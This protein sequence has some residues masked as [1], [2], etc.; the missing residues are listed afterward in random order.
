MTKTF[1]YLIDKLRPIKHI[2]QHFP[3]F[4]SFTLLRDCRR[5]KPL[6]SSSLMSIPFTLSI[7]RVLVLKFLVC[8]LAS[9]YVTISVDHKRYQQHKIKVLTFCQGFEDLLDIVASPC[10]GAEVL[11][12]QLL[13]VVLCVVQF[14]LSITL[15]VA[16]VSHYYYRKLRTTLLSQLLDPT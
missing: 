2:Q 7:P 8:L 16:L 14:Y 6:S 12:A 1:T 11:H 4:F 15:Q 3:F 5:S 13:G 10:T 9:L